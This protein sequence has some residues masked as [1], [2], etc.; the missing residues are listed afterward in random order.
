MQPFYEKK[1]DEFR[2]SA[3]KDLTFPLHLHAAAELIFVRNGAI[4]VT[5]H[6]QTRTLHQME[7]A[8]IFPDMLHGYRT[9]DAS[10]AVL[11]IFSP[12]HAMGYYHALCRQ[13]PQCPFF[14]ADGYDADLPAAFDRVLQYANRSLALCE[15]WLNL[16][17]AYLM[18]DMTLASRDSRDCADIVYHLVSYV[19]AHFQEPLTLDRLARELHVNKYYVSRVFSGRLH[20]GFYDFVNRLRLDYAA[21]L[22]RETR[23]SITDIWQEAGF[24]SQKTF[25]RVFRSCYRMTPSQYRTAQRPAEQALH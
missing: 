7:A 18:S 1:D 24:E 20:C 16:I 6:D 19:S 3:A 11:C 14:A 15:A 5:V 10:D 13:Q 25:N 8:L 21:R 23:R 2:C 4:E 9:P 12:S 22:L 17:L